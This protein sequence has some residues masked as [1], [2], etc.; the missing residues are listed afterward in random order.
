MTS[1]SL[2]F[3]SFCYSFATLFVLCIVCHST[4]LKALATCGCAQSLPACLRMCIEGMGALVLRLFGLLSI[5]WL[6]MGITF[7]VGNGSAIIIIIVC[8]SVVNRNFHFPVQLGRKCYAQ[9]TSR[10]GAITGVFPSSPR[11]VPS[12]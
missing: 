10:Q 2:N 7:S 1:L 12:F 6:A 3:R 4:L 9:L 11:S 5:I 8:L